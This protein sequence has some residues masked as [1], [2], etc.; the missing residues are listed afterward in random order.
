MTSIILQADVLRV[1]RTEKRP[2]AY[3]APSS[4]HRYGNVWGRSF[5]AAHDQKNTADPVGTVILLPWRPSGY[6]LILVFAN[7][8]QAIY[9]V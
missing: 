8:Y 9:G 6:Y 3:V 5:G 2:A 1:H 7:P 4:R